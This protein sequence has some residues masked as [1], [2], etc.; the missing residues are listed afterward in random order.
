[1]AIRDKPIYISTD[2]SRMLWL[3]SQSE[4]VTPEARDA[5]IKKA[6]PDEIADVFL[7]QHIREQYPTLPEHLSQIDKLER[8]VIQ[9]LSKK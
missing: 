6:T 1:M 4:T 5:G 7:R 3:I 8:E 9:K 2:V